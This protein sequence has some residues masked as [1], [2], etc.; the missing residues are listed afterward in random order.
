M[1]PKWDD[2]S[3]STSRSSRRPV[4]S[5]T[6]PTEIWER[7][8]DVIGEGLKAAGIE[9]ADLAAIGITNQRETTVVWDQRTGEPYHHAIVWQDTRTDVIAKQLE[10]DGHGDLIRSR[11]GLPPASYFAGGKLRWILENVDGVRAD[12]EAGHA[13]F[14]TMD[15]WVL[16][17]LTGL[18]LTDV[19]NASRTML[20]DL[21]TL[22]WDDELLGLFGVPRAMLPEIRS[23]SEVYGTTRADG[24]FGAEV[25][26]PAI[27]ATSMPPS[28]VRSASS[29][30]ASRTPTARATSW[31]STPAPRSSGPSTASSRR[32]ATVSA[33]NRPCT[34]WKGRSP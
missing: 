23:S 29:R 31:C 7:T 13:L 3:S 1:V 5:S 27:S 19:T 10:R 18:H 26:S 15:T 2:T 30:E 12:A 9:S 11:T 21:E 34:R 14:G 22:D 16:W 20:M 32:S 17:Q 25:P 33:T 4:G 28:S 24:P 8:Q 6:T